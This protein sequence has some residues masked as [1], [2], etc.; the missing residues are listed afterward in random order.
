LEKEFSDNFEN[1]FEHKHILDNFFLEIRLQLNKD[2]KNPILPATMA[3]P[4]L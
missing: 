1:R 3:Y 4:Q 2:V